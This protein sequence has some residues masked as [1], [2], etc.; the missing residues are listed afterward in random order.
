A[1]DKKL[2]KIMTEVRKIC[3]LG[4]E[5]R[6]K[7]GI[8]VRQPL[9]SLKIKNQKSKIKNNKE[10]LSL[11]SDEINVR[12]IIFDAK[13]E[14]KVELDTKI[15][16]EL[17]AEGQLRGFIRAIQDL[18]KKAGLAPRQKIE[19][20]I[21]TGEDFVKNFSSEIKRGVNAGAIKFAKN[22]GEEIKIDG[23]EFKIKIKK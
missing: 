4:L 23:M 3:S 14:N 11:I 19:L 13:I 17:K 5:A 10:L 22:D 21:E 2:L 1:I 6:A 12:G 15:T 8:K 7:A 20:I 16:P 18:R 9:A